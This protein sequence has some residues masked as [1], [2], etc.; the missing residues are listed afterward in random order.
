MCRRRG[1]GISVLGLRCEILRLRVK[2]QD[3]GLRFGVED[4]GI[5]RGVRASVSRRELLATVGLKLRVPLL[6]Q[7]LKKLDMHTCISIHT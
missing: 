3:Y 6:V 1:L 7:L 5:R 2:V 4:L